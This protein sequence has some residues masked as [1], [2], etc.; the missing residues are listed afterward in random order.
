MDFALKKMSDFPQLDQLSVEQQKARRRTR[1]RLGILVV[2]L[3][4]MGLDY[5][6]SWPEATRKQRALERAVNALPLPPTTVQDSAQAGHKPRSGFISRMLLSSG[7]PQTV[8]EFFSTE[9]TNEGWTAVE[10]DCVEAA[11][12][13]NVSADVHTASGYGLLSFAREGSTCALRYY[14][15]AN[16]AKRKYAIAGTWGIK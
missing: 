1:I 16:G 6:I 9:L 15:Y 13:A 8:C 12:R 3:I 4:L 2:F 5:L 11:K 14:G 7:D 10:N